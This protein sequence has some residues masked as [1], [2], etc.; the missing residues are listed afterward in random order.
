VT[1]T[2]TEI[3]RARRTRLIWIVSISVAVELG[4]YA[5][6]RLAPVMEDLVHPVYWVVAVVCVLTV[7]HALRR[8]PGTDRRR[9]DRRETV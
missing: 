3:R 4:L 1:A 5:L 7:L 6:V 9:G 8:H 2:P